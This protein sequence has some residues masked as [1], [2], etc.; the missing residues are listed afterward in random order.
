MGLVETPRDDYI[1]MGLVIVDDV[2]RDDEGDDRD[3]DEMDDSEGDSDGD[4][5][6]EN[7]SDEDE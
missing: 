1:G 4:C 7:L 6:E 5:V 3:V 2:E